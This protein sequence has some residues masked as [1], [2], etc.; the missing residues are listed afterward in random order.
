MS[1]PSPYKTGQIAVPTSYDRCEK[2][3]GLIYT[4]E[5]FRACHVVNSQYKLEIIF[6]NTFSWLNSKMNVSWDFL[7]QRATSDLRASICSENGTVTLA[8][9]SVSLCL[10]SPGKMPRALS[11]P[12]LPSRHKLP[13]RLT[14]ARKG[15]IFT[16]FPPALSPPVEVILLA[17]LSA[18]VVSC[19]LNIYLLHIHGF[20]SYHPS[21]WNTSSFQNPPGKCLPVL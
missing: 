3:N 6:I 7:M 18:Q 14:W 11:E 19:F 20:F 21:A 5:G 2:L 9:F 12:V 8:A 1:H 15:R 4:C 17:W 13:D 10:T 16:P